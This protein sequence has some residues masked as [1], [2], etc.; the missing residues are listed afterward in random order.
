MFSA[1]TTSYFFVIFIANHRLMGLFK[2]LRLPKHARYNYIPRYYDPRKE[3][4]QDRL[5]EIELQRENSPEAMKSRISSGLKRGAGDGRTRR[6]TIL[7]SNFII[8]GVVVVL[9][10]LSILFIN[11]YVPRILESL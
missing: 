6:K 4:L 1:A 9:V 10:M 5:K 2:V 11:Y 3:E 8:L 7:R